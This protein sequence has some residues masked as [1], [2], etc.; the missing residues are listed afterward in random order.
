MFVNKPAL[1][2]DTYRKYL[3]NKL[4]E[5]YPFLGLPVLFKM[6]GRETKEGDS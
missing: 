6:R 4:R 3:E 1:L 2:T 5:S